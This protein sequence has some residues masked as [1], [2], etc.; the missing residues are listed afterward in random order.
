M[1]TDVGRNVQ[2]TTANTQTVIKNYLNEAYNELCKEA[3]VTNMNDSYSFSTVA[4]QKDYL[5]PDNFESSLYAL[6][7]TNNIKL[8]Q[9]DIQE[10]QIESPTSVDQSGSVVSY[11]ILQRPY[12]T[13][14]SSTL[15]IVSDSALDTSQTVRVR[16]SNDG[17]VISEDVT[18]TGTTPVTTTNS[19]DDIFSI[20]SD[21]ARAGIVTIT[22]GADTVAK[23]GPTIKNYIAII[24]RLFN[25]PT[26]VLTIK[27]PYFTTNLPLIDD[28]DVLGIVDGED[29]V[30]QR[31]SAKLWRRKRQNK[32]A[33]DFDVEAERA[34]TRLL[35]SRENQPNRAHLIQPQPYSRITV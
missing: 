12:F 23:I 27:S 11:A 32:K 7:S 20:S 31:A 28:N 5:M 3:N 13:K 8:K 25:I 26:Q 33:Q 34:L 9:V 17:I 24:M 16:G 4:G 22:S 18:L 10:Y 6:D 2:D 14:P 30:I 15:D 19:F 29:Y 1:I 21:T 35:W